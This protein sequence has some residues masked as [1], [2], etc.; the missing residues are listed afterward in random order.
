MKIATQHICPPIPTSALDWAAID[1]DTYDRAENSDCPVGYGA[2]EQEAVDDLPAQ[3]ILRTYPRHGITSAALPRRDRS[4]R[5]EEGSATAKGM[6][7]SVRT[8]P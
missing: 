1:A 6:R 8:P 5:P 3:G 2:T 7:L 4:L